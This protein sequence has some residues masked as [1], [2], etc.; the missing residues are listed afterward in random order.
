M[1]NF[2]NEALMKITLTIA[3]GAL[4]GGLLAL[5]AFAAGNSGGS[6]TPSCPSGQVYNQ[7]KKMCVDAQSGVI[8]DKSLTDYAYALAKDGRYQEA[9]ATLDLLQNPSTPEA[10]NYRGYATRKL[11]RVDEGIGYY[12]Q[13]VALD[14]DYTLVREY[15]GEAYLIKGDLTNAKLQLTEI[16]KR[17]GTTC[18]PYQDLA[19]AIADAI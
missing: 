11:G 15:L 10:L 9:L 8:D 1:A 18:E 7:Q 4:A 16:E 12:L 17:C 13:S 19:Q 5:P 14:P 2:R 3:A 6:D